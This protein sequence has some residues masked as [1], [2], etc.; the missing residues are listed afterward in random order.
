MERDQQDL[1]I[2]SPL[3]KLT[4][5]QIARLQADLVNI[6]HDAFIIRDYGNHILSWN[7]GARALYGWSEQEVLGQAM[8]ELLQTRFPESREAIDSAL[9]EHGRWEGHL[10]H[11]S[12][13]GNQ[14]VV[15]SR[16]VLVSG[17]ENQPTAVLEVNRDITVQMRLLRERAE[18]EASM[19]VFRETARQMDTFLGIVSHELKSPLTSVSGNIQLARRQ[20]ARFRLSDVLPPEVDTG[21]LDLIKTLLDR[22]EQQVS[23]QGRLINDLVD[24]S[25]IQNNQLDLRL[26]LCD[27]VPLVTQVVEEQR[28]MAATRAISWDAEVPQVEVVADADRIGQVVSN[29][30]SNALKYSASDQP[31]AVSLTCEEGMA[32]VTVSDHGPGLSAEQSAQIWERFVRIKGLEVKSGSGVGLGLGLYICR[33][34]IE[35][36]GG[37]VGVISQPGAGSTF[38]FTLPLATKTCEDA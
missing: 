7:Q 11:I 10:V 31:V 12:R 22:A 9:L 14:L 20:L 16:Q 33:N 8:H 17:N 27:L 29:Y 30:L 1:F 4:K 2:S 37:Q 24:S 21:A 25:R 26:A 28:S 36:Q 13:E 38:W 5:E 3:K 23:V 18:A 6:A 32:R 35:R 15:D 19:L 34:L